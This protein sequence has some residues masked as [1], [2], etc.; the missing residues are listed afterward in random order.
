MALDAVNLA[1]PVGGFVVVSGGDLR[2]QREKRSSRRVSRL[3]MPTTLL[4]I[5][6]KRVSNF[7]SILYEMRLIPSRNA[8]E[9]GH[10]S[11]C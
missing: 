5:M 3:S 2:I 1:G 8:A 6:S 7:D 10:P 9:H 4:S 11:F